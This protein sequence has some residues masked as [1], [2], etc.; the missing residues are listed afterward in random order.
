MIKKLIKFKIN[1]GKLIHLHPQE[2][3]TKIFKKY[4]YLN[5][6]QKIED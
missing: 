1:Y 3:E 4:N 2:K 5:L 6:P